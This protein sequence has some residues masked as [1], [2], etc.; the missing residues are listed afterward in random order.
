MKTIFFPILLWFLLANSVLAQGGG[1]TGLAFLKLG[2]G[3]RA[4]AMGEAYSAIASDPSAVYYNPAALSLSDNSQLLLMHKVWIQDT[5]TEFIAAKTTF[6][7]ISLG[8]GIN[9]TSVDNIEIRENPGPAIGT[10]SS[11]NA[12]IGISTSYQFS[13][14][15]SIGATGNFLYEKILVNEASG[16]GINAGALYLTPW[17]IRI[18]MSVGNIGS[19]SALDQSSS[20]LPTTVRFGGAYQ[21]RIEPIDGSLTAAADIVSIAEDTAPHLHAGAELEYKQQFALRAGYQTGYDTK[22]FSTGVGVRYG[23][24]RFDYAFMPVQFDL[25]SSHTFTV[26]IDFH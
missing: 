14:S 19:M 3:S 6:D 21:T 7:K 24:V 15:L 20:K 22:N 11:Q 2:V 5:R 9:S 13:S 17:N 8:I 1:K 23:V 16:I 4:L 25:G 10:F 18:G 26:L 12:A